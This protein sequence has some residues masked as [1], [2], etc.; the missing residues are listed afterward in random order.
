MPKTMQ[1]LE[2][3]DRAM[4]QKHYAVFE[5]VH[6]HGLTGEQ[7]EKL[8][9][10]YKKSSAASLRARKRLSEAWEREGLLYKNPDA[11]L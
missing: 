10:A 9:F 6:S 7:L 3:E 5:V 11:H 4:M 1:E 8:Y 2:A